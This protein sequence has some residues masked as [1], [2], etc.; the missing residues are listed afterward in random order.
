MKK[1]K[2]RMMMS[3]K[4]IRTVTRAVTDA[5]AVT[6]NERRSRDTDE[7]GDGNKHRERC[8][9]ESCDGDNNDDSNSDNDDDSDSNDD[10]DSVGNGSCDGYNKC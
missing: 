6:M 5:V 2:G 10:S 1:V 8:V 7:N 9:N 3:E 4:V